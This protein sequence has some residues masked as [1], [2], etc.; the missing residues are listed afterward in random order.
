[1]KILIIHNKYSIRGGEDTV[2]ENE[3]KLLSE[4]YQ[5]ESLIFQNKPNFL[6]LIQFITSIWNI[7]SSSKLKSKIKEFKPDY[8]H[9]HNLHFASGPLLI[10]VAKK[11]G[12]PLIMTLHN[13]RLL[14]PSATLMHNEKLFLE[15]LKSNFP[16]KAV[17][18]KVYRNSFFFTFLL[19]FINW[20]HEKI[21]TWRLI[22][23]YVCLTP[24]TKKLLLNSSIGIKENQ[25]YVKP[26]FIKS[27]SL[28]NVLP[29]SNHFLF[30]GRFS[31]EK[32]IKILLEAFNNSDLQLKIG[33]Y[34]PF[35][36]L[37]ISSSQNNN[38]IQFL[39]SL[40]PSQVMDELQK[41]TALIFPS[42]W[43]EGMPMTIIESF[44]VSTPVIASNI[45][46]MSM[47]IEHKQNG[48]LFA[49][50]DS[51]DLVSQ[52]TYWSSLNDN[53]IKK[54]RKSAFNSF[55]ENYSESTQLLFFEQIFELA[56]SH[57]KNYK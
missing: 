4:S 19:A 29:R 23:T 10:R 46:A 14:C 35:E 7:R 27:F 55:E 20:F 43:Y 56:K 18:S 3:L 32:G 8:I 36:D 17:R 1:M 50:S 26:N 34:G 2:F 37:V 47:M 5:V 40:E 42:I 9:F 30:L 25:I 39:G 49:S 15:S 28:N 41:C 21:G 53:A 24:L 11:K 54:I 12:I 51:S 16:W 45:G 48:L 13:Y 44:S 52:L 33:G 38:N 31:E 22:D 57:N 6:G